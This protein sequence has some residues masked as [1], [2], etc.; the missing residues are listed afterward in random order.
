MN[1]GPESETLALIEDTYEY[2]YGIISLAAMLNKQGKGRLIVGASK[3]GELKG[4]QVDDDTAE[5]Y[6][7]FLEH[8]IMPLVTSNIQI[9]KDEESGL[10]YLVVDVVGEDVPYQAFDLYPIREKNENV[11]IDCDLLTEIFMYDSTSP[12]KRIPAPRKDLTFNEL[13]PIVKEHIAPT[14]FSNVTDLDE[15]VFGGM[16]TFYAQYGFT[17]EKNTFNK[18]AYIMS[19]QSDACVLIKKYFGTDTKAPVNLKA[20]GNHSVVRIYEEI[21]SYAQNSGME[22]IIDIPSIKAAVREAFCSSYFANRS[23]PEISIFDDRL[24]IFWHGR[25]M[26]LRKTSDFYR[27]NGTLSNDELR[28]FLSAIDPVEEGDHLERVVK[29]YGE[30]A[31]RVGEQGTTVVFPYGETPYWVKEKTPV[32]VSLNKTER[33]IKRYLELNPKATVE[34]VAEKLCISL[35]T[36]K[37]NISKLKKYGIL[38]R[39]GTNKNGEWIV[40]DDI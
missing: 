25:M 40:N 14:A 3:D 10:S 39:S 26:Y 21:I 34:E 8:T 27:E 35:S 12:L 17:T 15:Y 4:I 9:E 30:D 28:L 38:D 7:F 37:W 16:D 18:F 5:M 1:F 24:E 2:E 11:E 23:N 31:I 13:F 29:I 19:D 6:L 22:T 33:R 36:A 32:R 20:Y